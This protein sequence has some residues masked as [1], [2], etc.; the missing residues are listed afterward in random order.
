[1]KVPTIIDALALQWGEIRATGA[2]QITIYITS[3][4]ID[5]GN[6]NALP[7]KISTLSSLIDISPSQRVTQPGRGAA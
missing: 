5:I 7:L 3:H 2:G 4:T 6:Y 1:M